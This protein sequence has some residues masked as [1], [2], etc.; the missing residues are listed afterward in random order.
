MI[1][2]SG[3]RHAILYK[4]PF[5]YCAHPHAIVTDRGTVLVI[6]NWAPRRAVILHPPED[7]LFQNVIVRSEDD[8]A[9][10]SVPQV[11]PGFGWQGT[12]STSLTRL[13]D[14]RIMV[15]QWRFNWY[16]LDL[17]R[18]LPDQRRLAYP[19]RIVNGWRNSPEH[20]A[21]PWRE[22]QPEE[23]APWV[24]GDGET[25]VHFSRDDGRSF[26]MPSRIA[27]A[28]LSGGYGN[29]G[30]LCL[31]DGRILLPLSD[32]PNF[33]T[34]FLVESADGGRT[35]TAPRV[36]AHREGSEFEEPTLLRTPSG[37]LLMV[38][39]DNGTRRLHQIVSEDDGASWTAPAPLAV[40]GYPGQLLLLPDGRILMTYGWR[41]PDYGVRA[42]LSDDEGSSWDVERTIRIRGALPNRNV[43][44]P[45][46]VI[47]RDAELLTVYYG[48]DADA[49]T[50]I[51]TTRWRI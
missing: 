11:V 2:A 30:A 8:G 9:S 46:T 47:T 25:W 29:R 34:V 4:D 36:V 14:G 38:L 16:P 7:P 37:R 41:Y 49:V 15:N 44:Y 26:G 23:L 35:W 32:V 13:P 45:A 28:P 48:E 43:G 50:C 10:W 18:T 33:R 24:R 39:R 1:D 19:E 51:M 27:T 31:P 21:G 12:E 42:V 3:A 6:F 20:E 40:T 5:A 22:R 17:A